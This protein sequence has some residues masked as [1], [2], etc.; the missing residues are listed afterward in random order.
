M[1]IITPQFKIK[2]TKKILNVLSSF[3]TFQKENLHKI[4]EGSYSY[5]MI[6]KK[7]VTLTHY[8]DQCI[9]KDKKYGQRI[10]QNLDAAKIYLIWKNRNYMT[11]HAESIAFGRT[12]MNIANGT[13]RIYDDKNYKHGITEFWKN[14]EL[15]GIEAEIVF[16]DWHNTNNKTNKIIT[17]DIGSIHLEPTIKSKNDPGDF[18]IQTLSGKKIVVDVK[19]SDDISSTSPYKSIFISPP[20][21]SKDTGHMPVNYDTNIDIYVSS[22]K[23]SEK[24]WWISGWNV[25]NKIILKENWLK[26]RTWCWGTSITNLHNPQSLL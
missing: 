21:S 7:S 8:I 15:L 23:L 10:K 14:H 11:S 13:V 24:T 6:F 19:G 16:F 1:S 18:T 22:R 26:A 25:E 9:I 12:L 4:E 17:N 5:E 3:E 20:G 2:Q